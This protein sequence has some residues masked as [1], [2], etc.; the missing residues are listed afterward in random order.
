M[1]DLK[2]H[3]IDFYTSNVNPNEIFNDSDEDDDFYED[4][5]PKYKSFE[6][7]T[8]YCI[9]MFTWTKTGKTIASVVEGFPPCSM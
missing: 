7:T 3:V 6:N 2:F 9:T 8:E 1:S 5:Q 4:E